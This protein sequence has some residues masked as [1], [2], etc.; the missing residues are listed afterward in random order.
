MKGLK[1]ENLSFN[2]GKRKIL[3]NINLEVP[4]GRIFC[5]L[6]PNGVGKSTLIKCIAGI[7]K[8]NNGRIILNGKDLKKINL[9]ELSKLIGYVPQNVRPIFSTTVFETILTSR[10]P[11]INWNPSKIDLEKTEYIIKKLGLEELAFRYVNEISG[12]E[13]QK[14]LI[15]MALV[16]E[17]ILLLLD[18]PTSNLDLKYQ[19]YVMK[20]IHEFVR[21]KNLI[22]IF[23][24]HDINLALKFS[25]IL[26]L[27]KNGR[28]YAIGEP[29]SILNEK[30]IQEVYDIKV[31]IIQY[32]NSIFVTTESL[33]L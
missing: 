10:I 24:T 16:K 1:I 13:W 20:I 14:V 23:T 28:I 4:E 17:P 8:P 15:A 22:A 26:V 30:I 29:C 3:E 32:N 7:L 27:M 33:A 6:G 21:S 9:N 19:V 25:D 31:K 2:Y 5:L 18:E 12:G 11:Y